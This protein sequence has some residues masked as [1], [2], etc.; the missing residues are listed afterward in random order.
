MPFAIVTIWISHTMV[1]VMS[2]TWVCS[3]AFK[4]CLEKS[5]QQR[6]CLTFGSSRRQSLTSVFRE[7]HGRGCGTDG[8]SSNGVAG[9]EGA[10]IVGALL[11]SL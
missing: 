3:C 7:V 10:S 4:V 9:N 8:V 5:R 11:G 2:R 1:Q 6:L